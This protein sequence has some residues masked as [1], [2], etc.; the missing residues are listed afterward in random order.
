[1]A[2]LTMSAGMAVVSPL[3]GVLAD[4]V[5]NRPL[6]VLGALVI[7][8]GMSTLL[9]VYPAA[10]PLDIAWRIALVGVGNGLFAGPNSAAILDATPPALTGTAGGVTSLLRTLG[11]AL[12]PALGA[13]AWTLTAGGTHG[14]TT[15]ITVL[16]GATVV[17][18]IA[19]AVRQPAGKQPKADGPA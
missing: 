10:G 14:F 11:F 1:M 4:R 13:L 12:G 9:L 15:G 3:A 7:L 18:L 6:V 16:A 17:A 8:A 2:L 19:S 5:G